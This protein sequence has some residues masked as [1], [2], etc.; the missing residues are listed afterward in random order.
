MNFHT[1]AKLFFIWKAY[2]LRRN[3]KG[4]FVPPRGGEGCGRGISIY[5]L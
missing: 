3:I 1:F 5:F 2:T 4:G